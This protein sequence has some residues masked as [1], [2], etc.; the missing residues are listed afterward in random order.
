MISFVAAPA[1]SNQYKKAVPEGTAFE[2][3]GM[4]FS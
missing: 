1:F 4:R 2:N 3:S